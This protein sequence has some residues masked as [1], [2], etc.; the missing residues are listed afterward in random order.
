MKGLIFTYLI[1]FFGV[2]GSVFSPFYGLLAYVALAILKPDAMWAHSIQNGRFSLIV[3]MAMLVSWMFRG[4]GN[5][6]LGQSS[7]CLAVSGCG[8]LHL[9]ASQTVNRMRG[10]LWSR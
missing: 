9:P 8:V 5:W 4:C 3:A 10:R 2:T 6:N 1:T 7:C